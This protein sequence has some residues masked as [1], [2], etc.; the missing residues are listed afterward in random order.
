MIDFYNQ[1]IVVHTISQFCILQ[2][3]K[4]LFIFH[5]H[6]LYNIIMTYVVISKRRT[7]DKFT[8][9]DNKNPCSKRQQLSFSRVS[10][11][12]TIIQPPKPGNVSLRLQKR[13]ET[14]GACCKISSPEP[15]KNSTDEMEVSSG[16]SRCHF[17]FIYKREFK[18]STYS[19]TFEL[20]IAS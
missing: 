3:S 10:A 20:L 16:Q 6:K 18:D 9:R 11:E 17:H 13:R 7:P 4:I 15:A 8:V 12:V 5:F 14:S 2:S 1:L 19:L